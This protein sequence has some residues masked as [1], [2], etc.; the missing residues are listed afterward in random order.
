MVSA[1]VRWG[2]A[3][4]LAATFAAT[5]VVGAWLVRP[6]DA[7]PADT[8][9][10]AS[11]LYFDRIVAGSHLEAFVNTTPKPLLTLVYGSLH[12]ITGDWRPGA[13]VTVLVLAAGVVMAAELVRRIAGPEAAVFAAVALVG[14]VALLAEVSWGQGLPWA[15]ALWIAAGLALTRPRPRYGLAGLFL[16]VAALSR[17]ET[18]LFLAVAT[19]YVAWRVLRGQRSEWSGGLILVGWGALA[20]IAVHDVLLTGDPLWWVKVSSISAAGHAPSLASAARLNVVHLLTVRYLLVVGIVGAIALIRWRSWFAFW[21]LACMGPL[22]ALFTFVLAFRGLAVLGH[23]FHPVELAV[24]LSAAIGAG[25]VLAEV[26]RRAVARAPGRYRHGILATTTAA[27]ALAAVVLSSPFAPASVSG[28]RAIGVQA[29]AAIRV[30]TYAPF[31]ETALP[32][33]PS[34][35]PPDPG[36]Y[37]TPVPAD[38]LLLAPRYQVNRLA[39][40]LRF[41]ISRARWLE[42]ARVDLAGGYPAV[43]SLLYF[44]GVLDPTTVTEETAVLRPSVPTVVGNVRVVPVFVDEAGKVWIERI[45]SAP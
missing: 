2:R 6:F 35:G 41:P 21:A 17:Q 20:L 39:V 32:T 37:A 12:S 29:V 24:I 13:W 4:A 30:D 14:S 31:L 27:A 8:D 44:D 22:V 10:A 3:G 43:G 23:Y 11:V 45:E 5:V 40:I 25:A 19:A 15:F 18:F 33:I 38:V 42:P 16:L 28:R 26:R 36:P 1:S 7:G 34:P 9:A